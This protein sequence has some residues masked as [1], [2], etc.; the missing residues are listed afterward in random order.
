LSL[1]LSALLIVA[2][3]DGSQPIQQHIVNCP[4]HTGIEFVLLWSQMLP[5]GRNIHSD[6]A[7]PALSD[8]RFELLPFGAN[9][10]RETI[11]VLDQQYITRSAVSEQAEQL[12]PIQARAGLVLGVVVADAHPSLL[13][14]AI[15]AAAGTLSILLVGRGTKVGADEEGHRYY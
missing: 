12:G 4:K 13:G 14:K 15:Q 8:K 7:Y 10:A 6:D 5:G 3:R 9:Q 2:P 1:P 11:H